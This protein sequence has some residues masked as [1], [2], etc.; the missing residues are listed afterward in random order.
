M[1]GNPREVGL[2][3]QAGAMR[4]GIAAG[5]LLPWVARYSQ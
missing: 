5:A 3:R 2:D 4:V 1:L